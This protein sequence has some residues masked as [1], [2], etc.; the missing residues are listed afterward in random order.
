MLRRRD[1]KNNEE[2]AEE[3]S[4]ETPTAERS[5]T[6]ATAQDGGTSNANISPGGLAWRPMRQTNE[7]WRPQTQR[8]ASTGEESIIGAEDFFNGNYRSER[9]V[10]VQG[11]VEGS[12]ESKGHILIE[13]QAQV[14]AD[15]T[16]EDI[17]VAGRYNGKV[18]CRRRFEI[19][20]SGVVTGEINTDLLVVQEGGYF[21]GKLKMKDRSGSGRNSP[22][23]RPGEQGGSDTSTTGTEEQTPAQV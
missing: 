9:G 13:D 16:A 3:T 18:E 21:D 2:N 11:R 7:E 15:M 12:I 19:T 1:L 14:M 23:Q 6:P 5:A 4:A 22:T 17:T 20:P 10:R 8:A